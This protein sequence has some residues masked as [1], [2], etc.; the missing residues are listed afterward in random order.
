[1]AS[2]RFDKK[3]LKKLSRQELLELLL[4]QSEELQQCRA[5]NAD[6]KKKLADRNYK[7]DNAGSIAVASLSL[8][9]IFD[10]AQKAADE[11]L[12]NVRQL[13]DRQAKELQQMQ[14]ESKR[15]LRT[16]GRQSREA[17]IK[18]QSKKAAGIAVIPENA[19]AAVPP[20]PPG[21]EQTAAGIGSPGKGGDQ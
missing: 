3:E 9:G 18:A 13:A 21:G 19:A 20:G 1:M 15:R 16:E 6:L 12:Y 14:L 11:Y 5:E 4:A 7:L 2:A 8:S 17:A 10:A